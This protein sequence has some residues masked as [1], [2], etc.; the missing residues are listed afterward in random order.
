MVP[1]NG[2]KPPFQWSLYDLDHD[3]SQ[4]TD[5]AAKQPDRV[6]AMIATWRREAERNNVFPLFHTAG[7]GRATAAMMGGSGRKQF[8]F[9]E[10]RK[11]AD[12]RRAAP[13]RAFVHRRC[14]SRTG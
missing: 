11:S 6:Q 14:R 10:G 13:D 1:K 7:R 12:L 8:D 5:L 9:W 3:F 4:S 2:P